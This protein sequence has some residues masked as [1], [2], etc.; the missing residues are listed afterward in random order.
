MLLGAPP[1]NQGKRG[2]LKP[3]SAIRYVKGSAKGRYYAGRSEEKGPP[4]KTEKVP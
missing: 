1:V 2:D 3:F 4:F